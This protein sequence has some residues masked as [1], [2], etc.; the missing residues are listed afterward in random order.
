MARLSL[1]F[2][3][4]A[5]I[6]AAALLLC[7]APAAAQGTGA[8]AGYKCPVTVDIPESSIPAECASQNSADVCNT[9]LGQIVS[10]GALAFV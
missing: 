2:A 10:K 5:A 7:A 6:I 1:R 8:A 3:S 4:A 9:C